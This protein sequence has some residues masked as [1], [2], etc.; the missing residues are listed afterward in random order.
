MRRPNISETIDIDLA[1]P[2]FFKPSQIDIV[3]GSDLM[4]QILQDGVKHNV[5]GNLLAQNSIFGWYLSEPTKRE[6]I[7]S[8]HTHVVEDSEDLNSQLK[9]FWEIEE[10]PE[11]HPPSE[12][13]VFC[14]NLYLNTT[15]R[16]E[17]G[18]N[19]VRLPFKRTFPSQL[20]LGRSRS[21]A[22]SQAFRMEHTLNKNPGL[23]DEYTQVLE[24]YLT[25]RHMKPTPSEEIHDS[26]TYL[27]FYLPHHSG[28]RAESKTT[29][30]RV[31]FN[32]SKP[33]ETGRPKLTNRFDGCNTK[34]ASL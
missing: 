11:H 26:G 6:V 20:K 27:S 14:E 22:M 34:L 13:D 32:A 16:Q 31:V 17:D 23:K 3:L 5:F 7:S 10:L 33:S 19:V 15:Y 2:H 18:R 21:K 29:K 25:L 8:Y 9:K 12:D 24:E 4:P 28:I 30:V 1:D